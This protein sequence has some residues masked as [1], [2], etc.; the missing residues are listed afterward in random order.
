M[1]EMEEQGII[2]PADGAR[3]RE[4]LISSVA[5]LDSGNSLSDEI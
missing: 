1:E 3:P 2:G 4:V 5:E